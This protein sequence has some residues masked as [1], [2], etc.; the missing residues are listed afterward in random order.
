MMLVRHSK[1]LQRQGK[2]GCLLFK[3]KKEVT[4]ACDN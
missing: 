3:E 1:D 2:E 4:K